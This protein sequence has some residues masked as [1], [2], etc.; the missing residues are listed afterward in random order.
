VW[1]GGA[2]DTYAV[3][4]PG[5]DDAQS[6]LHLGYKRLEILEPIAGGTDDQDADGQALEILLELDAS[7]HREEHIKFRRC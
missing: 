1:L 6:I 3:Y 7:V 4:L 5:L 2:S